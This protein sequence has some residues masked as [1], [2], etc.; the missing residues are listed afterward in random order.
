[1]KNFL[2]SKMREIEKKSCQKIKSSDIRLVYITE[3]NFD[4]YWSYWI[5]EIKRV[6]VGKYKADEAVKIIKE[7]RGL[8]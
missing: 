4:V 3:Y 1:M 8:V 6:R 7:A 2:K 5:L